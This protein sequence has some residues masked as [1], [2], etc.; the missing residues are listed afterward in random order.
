MNQTMPVTSVFLNFFS[1]Y[2]INL[3]KFNMS[4]K[5]RQQTANNKLE[6]VCMRLT[7][8]HLKSTVDWHNY[9]WRTRIVLKEKA[10]CNS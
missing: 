8:L 6:T 7:R 2:V 5:E 1:P 9:L 3:E 10:L 4:P